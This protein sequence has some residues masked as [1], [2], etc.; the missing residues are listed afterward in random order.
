M[1]TSLWS[2]EQRLVI[3]G[4]THPELALFM[5]PLQAKEEASS[6]PCPRPKGLLYGLGASA[7]PLPSTWGD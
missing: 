7:S 4:F 5:S 1:W 6:W 3:E 2:S